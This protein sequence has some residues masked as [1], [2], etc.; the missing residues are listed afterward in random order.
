MQSPSRL[1]SVSALSS[2]NGNG[3]PLAEA[4]A[5]KVSELRAVL[6]TA[7]YGTDGK[8]ADLVQRYV[9][10]RA[11]ARSLASSSPQQK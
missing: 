5:M 9:E 10:Y 11:A 8:K 2:R 4:E 3:N 7:G 6:Q 1:E